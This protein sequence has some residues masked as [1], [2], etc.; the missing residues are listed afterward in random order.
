MNLTPAADSEVV[1]EH[2]LGALDIDI[3]ELHLKECV[4]LLFLRFTR[5]LD[6]NA[7]TV[8]DLHGLLQSASGRFAAERLGRHCF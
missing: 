5:L 6:R 2:L 1:A 8:L 3:P 4:G 7:G